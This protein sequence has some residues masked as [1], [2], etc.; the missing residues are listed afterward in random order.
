MQKKQPN[1][2]LGA[3]VLFIIFS[4]LFFV[5]LFRFISI[6]ITG[7][8]AGQNLAAKAHQKY[9]K[10]MKIEAK[11]GTIYDRK[12]EVVAED[13]VS[14][15]LV[16]I[17]DKSMTTNPNKPQHVVDPEMTARK[18]AKYI[19]LSEDE[20]YKRLT[21]KGKFQVEFGK[22]GR[23]LSYQTKKKIEELKL[24]GI[25]FRR[26]MKRF[27]PNGIFASHVVGF[28]EK[29]ED[30]K[31]NVKLVGKIG[32][33]K[34]LNSELTGKDGSVRFESDSWGILLPDGK[35]KIKPA[36][37]G[38]DV[39]LTIDKKIQ[40][41]LEDALSK[42]DKEYNPAKIIAIVAD[43]KTGEILAMGQRPTFN[44]ETREGLEKSW[45]NEAVENAIEPGSTMKIFTLAAAIQE[46]VFNPNEWY[47]SGSYRVTK[48]SP[49]I[50]DH[51]GSGWGTITYLEGIQRSS[52][53]AVAKI[54]NEKLGFEKFREYLTKFGF[55]KPTGIDLPNEVTGKIKYDWPIEKIT[56]AYGQ[57]TTVTPIQLIQAAIAIANDGK[58]L[59][60]HVIDKIVDS[61]T[62]KVIRETKPEVTGTPISKETAKKVRDILGTVV[63]SPK[64]T[65]Y[66]RYNI[67][68]YEVAGKTGTA[69][70]PG[71]N[72]KYLRGS[73]DYLFSFLG[74]APK[75]NPELIMYV[76][77]QQPEVGTYA[78]G[79]KPVSKIF[80]TVMKS[81]LQ[82]LN[83]KPVQQEKAVAN[84][85]PDVTGLS[86]EKATKILQA[87]GF[88][89]VLTGKGKTIEAQLPSGNTTI[90]EG[91]KIILKTEGDVTV[92]DM[93]GWSRR[94]VMK[95]AKIGG[96]Q[97]NITGSGYVVNQ[98]PNPGVFLKKGEYLIVH[99]EPPEKQ[100]NN[101]I[102]Q[103]SDEQNAVKD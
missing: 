63:S 88:D 25:T 90:L 80:N 20:I 83:I 18:L 33:E 45:Y 12:G 92:P 89:I 37:N 87:K 40:T 60:P 26:E 34:A 72:G 48:N 59:K 29:E 52:N 53:V 47:K 76:A 46:N 95:F 96:L 9:M 91:E 32:I 19:D 98:K 61:Q 36:K 3:A 93:T 16:A 57:G 100:T 7:E 58:M 66:N 43:P 27:Y 81:S 10:E 15:T 101:M 35:E 73:N 31:G 99:L 55:D 94:D 86:V 38:D 75:D 49:V 22:A 77:V 14:Y 21:V 79:Y 8:A 102:D 74:M 4:L 103:Q 70:I 39:Y 56:T 50:R 82:Y 64:G 13:G 24:P 54:V 6:Q 44:P 2:N 85:V 5:L 28:V 30:K 65:G 62:G 41:F 23:D 97:L 68:G 11:R 51:N 67:K 71:P 69:N 17:L 78:D 84:L 1:M 42:V